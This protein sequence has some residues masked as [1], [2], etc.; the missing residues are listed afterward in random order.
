MGENERVG[1]VGIF[2]R[3]PNER[4]WL[5]EL[6]KNQKSEANALGENEKAGI[7]ARCPNERLWPE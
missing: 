4:L 2:A 3:W 6:K 1:G 5:S 7:F